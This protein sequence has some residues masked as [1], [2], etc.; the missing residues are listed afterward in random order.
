M[1]AIGIFTSFFSVFVASFL[2]LLLK[3]QSRDEPK[4]WFFSS[5]VRS[6]ETLYFA[7]LRCLDAECTRAKA[8]SLFSSELL[9]A[10]SGTPPC[11][12]FVMLL[13]SRTEELVKA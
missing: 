4:S 10:M 1:P 9:V 12:L 3:P 6:V 7:N 2:R 5:L 11:N 8:V 13:S